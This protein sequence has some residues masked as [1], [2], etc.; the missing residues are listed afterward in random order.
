MT[1]GEG[2]WTTD[3]REM[4]GKTKVRELHAVAASEFAHNFG[5]YKMEAQHQAVPVS[6]HGSV[7]GYFVSAREYEQLLELKAKRRVVLKTADLSPEEAEELFSAQMDP[8]HD[9]L[10]K[11]LDPK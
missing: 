5:R 9:H 10:N 6:S 3:V 2:G 4:P 7:V 8:R 1:V 11:L